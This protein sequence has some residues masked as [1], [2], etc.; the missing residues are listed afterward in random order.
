[1]RRIQTFVTYNQQSNGEVV[2][3]MKWQAACSLI[4]GRIIL[5]YAANDR[6]L[7]IWAALRVLVTSYTCVNLSST[8]TR[9]SKLTECT[10]Q[11]SV[12]VALEGC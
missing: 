12:M 3:Y 6:V 5:S 2:T 1:M 11:A 4:Y 8:G 10:E 7:F 9:R